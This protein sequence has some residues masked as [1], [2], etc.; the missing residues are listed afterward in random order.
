MRILILDDEAYRHVVLNKKLAGN[1]IINTYTF[2]QAIAALSGFKFDVLF[3]DHD[4]EHV[5]STH[6]GYD[7]CQFIKSKL[8]KDKHPNQVVIH[9]MNPVGAHQMDQT[10]QGLGFAVQGPMSL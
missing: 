3:L 2:D 4:L 6:T 8:P 1:E 5:D 10:L 9:S 7:V